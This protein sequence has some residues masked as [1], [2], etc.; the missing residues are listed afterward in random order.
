MAKRGE[1]KEKILEAAT[2]VFFANGFEAT[3]VKMVLEEADVVTGSF[4]HFF[5]S[6]EA[7]F[8]V[9]VERF[10]DQYTQKVFA[11]LGNETLS[12]TEILEQFMVLLQITSRDYFESLQ[13]DRLHWTVQ[14]ALHERL[15][16]SM[17]PPVAAFL[18]SRQSAGR[19]RKK[20]D[21]D[22]VTFARILIRGFEAII[23]RGP[24]MPEKEQLRRELLAFWNMLIEV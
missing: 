11:I 10:L 17:I 12:E 7:L 4:Y 6:K 21:V 2:K 19:I 24:D 5:P 18:S 9:V 1:T 16:S 3:S 13:G 15:V 20:L 22:D 8:E 23:H 14:S